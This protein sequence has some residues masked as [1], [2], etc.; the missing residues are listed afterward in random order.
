MLT[1]HLHSMEMPSSDTLI[2]LKQTHLKYAQSQAEIIKYFS[3][4]KIYLA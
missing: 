3:T 4:D 2:N 1:A